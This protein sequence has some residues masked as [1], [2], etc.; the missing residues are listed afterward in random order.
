MSCAGLALAACATAP[1]L[2]RGTLTQ[3]EAKE[4]YLNI[5]PVDGGTVSGQLRVDPFAD[6]IRLSGTLQGFPSAGQF[7]FHIKEAADCAGSE[8]DLRTVFNPLGSRHG[9]YAHGEHM[10]GD[11]DNL[12]V[13]ADGTVRL[14]RNIQGVTLGGGHYNDVATRS[15]VVH[16]RAD[17]YT[18][19]PDGNSG[20]RIG[21]G[22]V[23]I[24]NPPPVP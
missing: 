3:S 4:A 8:A 10:L 16:A 6:G 13:E 18:T 20:S 12:D 17:D 5:T 1:H 14:N 23:Q 24:I 21:C 9:R 11:M 7:A 22:V 15:F 2:P 19:Q